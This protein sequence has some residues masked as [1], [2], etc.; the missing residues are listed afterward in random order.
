MGNMFFL[1]Y[2]WSVETKMINTAFE[3]NFAHSTV[4]EVFKKFRM[5]ASIFYL[6][7]MNYQLVVDQ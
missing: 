5:L 6:A 7:K 3:Y 4:S 1:L 2:E